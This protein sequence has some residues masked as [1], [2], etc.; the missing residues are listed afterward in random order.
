[1]GLLVGLPKPAAI[2]GSFA[3]FIEAI[4]MN[5]SP[6]RQAGDPFSSYICNAAANPVFE[7][8]LAVTAKNV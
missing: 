2:A 1:M 3:E 6:L 7:G 4:P 8:S 5:A